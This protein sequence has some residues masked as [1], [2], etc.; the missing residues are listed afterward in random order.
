ML[1]PQ[2]SSQTDHPGGRIW[3]GCWQHAAL[4]ARCSAANAASCLAPHAPP[5]LRSSRARPAV[6]ITAAV[7]GAGAIAAGRGRC[8][9]TAG[10]FGEPHETPQHSDHQCDPAVRTCNCPTLM[11]S[12]QEWVHSA[13][14][15]P[16]LAHCRSSSEQV[17]KVPAQDHLNVFWGNNTASPEGRCRPKQRLHC[18]VGRLHIPQACK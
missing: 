3:I 7:G 14:T 2:R 8:A 10:L 4:A 6:V 9:A 1:S 13:S 5:P 17:R 18:A 12:H 16:D 15:L 11:Q